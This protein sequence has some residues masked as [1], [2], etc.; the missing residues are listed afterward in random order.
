M[1]SE[2][3]L[4]ETGRPTGM[5]FAHP[6]HEWF[7]F[8]ALLRLQPNLYY[9]SPG[10][11]ATEGFENAFRE[12]LAAIGFQG[13]VTFGAISESEIYERYLAHD[14][15]WFVTQRNAIA[16]WLKQFQPG[17]VCTDPFEWYNSAHDLVPLLV[18][19]AVQCQS[20]QTQRI[21]LAEHGL[22][23][24]TIAW[25]QRKTDDWPSVQLTAD[26]V[27]C[28]RQFLRDM[29]GFVSGILQGV[30]DELQD[31]TKDWR[32]REFYTE[33]YRWAPATRVFTVP[34]DVGGW[35]TYDQR[36]YWRVASGR[37]QQ[38]ITFQEHFVPLA[39][40]LLRQSSMPAIG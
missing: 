15:D 7:A 17:L 38:A 4:A 25:Q 12:K 34:P 27:D 21:S 26:E 20:S 31:V 13:T 30:N 37:A 40:K 1:D 9:L 33:Y 24:Q 36:G 35:P 10:I 18:A 32:E 14:N 29:Q 23:L 28:K 11:Y 39:E 6:A 2:S 22:G 16:A 3:V 5:V 8:A 19:S